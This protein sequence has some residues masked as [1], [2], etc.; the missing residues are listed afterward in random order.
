MTP[1]AYKRILLKISG[2]ILAGAQPFGIDGR[3]IGYLAKEI[4]EV[5]VMLA[6]NGYTTGQTINVNGGQYL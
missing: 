5:V 1:P 6:T 3:V 4:A 2:E